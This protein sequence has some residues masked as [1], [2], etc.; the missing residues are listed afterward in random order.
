MPVTFSN[1]HRVPKYLEHALAFDDY[2]GRE[3]A[4][5]VTTLIGPPQIPCLK[6]TKFYTVDV[7]S[8]A[9]LMYGMAIHA[10]IAEAN[11]GKPGYVEERFSTAIGGS[12]LTGKPDYIL[13]TELRDIKT[14]K[15]SAVSY[16]VKDEWAQQLNVYRW[17]VRQHGIV[18][19]DLYVDALV[20]DFT[21]WSQNAAP[22][23]TLKVPT[24][25]LSDTKDFIM[26]RL[27][28]YSQ[29]PV[30]LCTPDE[31][32]ERG[33]GYAII[34]T[35]NTRA[36]VVLD[37][38]EEVDAWLSDKGANYSVEIRY[39]ERVRCEHYCEV[40]DVCEQYETFKRETTSPG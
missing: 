24:W 11:K 22:V 39:P 31:C 19:N 20:K 28:L 30:P 4:I 1:T 23:V 33:G 38:K 13:G 16:G 14:I 6:G 5:S 10:W 3:T 26:E 25:L 15:D 12:V 18:V 37:T 9:N 21:P 36:S 27:E 8:R 34:K 35:G 17:L 32:W 2:H 7:T 29:D 40:R